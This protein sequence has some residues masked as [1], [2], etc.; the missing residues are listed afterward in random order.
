M[1][2]NNDVN[3]KINVTMVASLI[4]TTTNRNMGEIGRPPSFAIFFTLHA[5]FS[6]TYVVQY[7]Y[8]NTADEWRRGSLHSPLSF[9]DTH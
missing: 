2:E 5:W 8:V 7:L 4:R 9:L 3:E 6:Q 1:L